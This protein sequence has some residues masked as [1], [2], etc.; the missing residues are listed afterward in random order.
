MVPSAGRPLTSRQLPSLEMPSKRNPS[1][2]LVLSL[3]VKTKNRSSSKAVNRRA[4]NISLSLM[5]LYAPSVLLYGV[6]PCVTNYIIL[7]LETSSL[8]NLSELATS[9]VKVLMFLM[10][11]LNFT[12]KLIMTLVKEFRD[13]LLNKQPKQEAKVFRSSKSFQKLKH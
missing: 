9:T 6:I 4:G 10:T 5:I 7:N 1:M 11:N 2:P 3:N 12:L 13:G 8:V